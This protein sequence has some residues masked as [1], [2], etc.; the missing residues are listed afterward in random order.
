VPESISVLEAIPVLE[1]PSSVFREVVATKTTPAK[2]T[3]MTTAE[4]ATITKMAT[5]TGEMATT[6]MATAATEASTMT[7][8]ETSPS[9]A[10]AE[11][12]GGHNRQNTGQNQT[13][14][15]TVKKFHKKLSGGFSS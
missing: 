1:M 6:K 14:K 7:A 15:E 4:T 11:C 8:P 9:S 2:P 3:E 10:M 12:G 5:A 13:G